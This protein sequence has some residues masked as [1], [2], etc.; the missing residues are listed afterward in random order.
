M[1]WIDTITI[2]LSKEGIG[3]TNEKMLEFMNQYYIDSKRNEIALE[4]MKYEAEA[5]RVAAEQKNADIANE[6]VDKF[7]LEL[8]EGGLLS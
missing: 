4:R 8:V 3:L 2:F 6:A 7:T 1:V 5:A